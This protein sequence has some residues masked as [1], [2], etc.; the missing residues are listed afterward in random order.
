MKASNELSNKGVT[1]AEMT[2]YVDEHNLSYYELATIAY[3]E[4]REDWI[5]VLRSKNYR[6]CL[7]F[8]IRSRRREGLIKYNKTL[9]EAMHDYATAKAAYVKRREEELEERLEEELEE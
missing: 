6:Q 5:R 8:Y 7:V 3:N 9:T 2:D 4:D 1:L